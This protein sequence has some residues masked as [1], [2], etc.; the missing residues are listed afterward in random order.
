MTERSLSL[1]ADHEGIDV[2]PGSKMD[3]LNLVAGA[4]WRITLFV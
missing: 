2:G 1:P 4:S 3:D